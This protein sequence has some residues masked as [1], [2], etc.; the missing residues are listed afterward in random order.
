MRILL[1]CLGNICR[2][3]M[4]EGVLRHLAEE[5]GIAI[6]TDS[7]GTG[8]YHVGEAPDARAQ[9][10]ML[11][12]GLDISDLRARQFVQADFDRFD[13]LLAMD[14]ENLRNMRRL[15]PSPE[16]ASKAMLI[17]EHAPA[18]ALREVPD[19]YFGGDEGFDAVYDML[20]LACGN[21]LDRVHG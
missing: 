14:A 20:T 17:M 1:V 2:S 15:A 8:D 13:L 18:H 4:A 5:R 10:A 7:A 3:P 9:A 16:H 21:L 6:E 11:R 12:R 19:P